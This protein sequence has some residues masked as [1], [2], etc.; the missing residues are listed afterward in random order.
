MKKVFVIVAAI[1]FLFLSSCKKDKTTVPGYEETLKGTSWGGKYYD[2]PFP[3]ST[4]VYSIRF[5]TDNSSTFNWVAFSPTTA[6]TGTWKV[7]GNIITFKFSSG[8]QNEWSG[9]ID[10]DKLINI[11]KPVPAGFVFINCDKQ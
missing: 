1:S 5:N 8:A 6:Y 7:N 9:Q 4:R 2:E 3:A 10:G 11:S